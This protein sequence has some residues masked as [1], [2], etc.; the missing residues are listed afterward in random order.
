[1][2]RTS[3]LAFSLIIICSLGSFAT[4]DTGFAQYKIRRMSPVG[5]LGVN[6]QRDVRQDKWGF[7]WVITVNNLFRFD[8]Y[9]FKHYTNKL[10]KPETASAWSFERLEVDKSGDIYITSNVGLLKYNPLTDNFDYLVRGSVKMVEEDSQGRLWMSTPSALGLYN[11]KTLEFSPI[12]SDAGPVRN[13]SAICVNSRR[14]YV[15]T[16]TGDIYMFDENKGRCKHVFSQPQYNIVD[17]SNT[18]SILYVLTE[19]MGL[20]KISADTYREVQTYDFFYP[21]RDVRVSARALFIDKY[22]HL[23]I[24]S[25]RG[26]YIFNPINEEYTHYAYDKN[27]PYGMPSSSVWRISEDQQG[28]LWFGTYSGGLCFVNLN[29]RKKLRTFNG[30]IDDLSYTVVSS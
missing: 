15:G 11:R 22:K 28:N 20:I 21:E 30:R 18:D 14:I 5:G 8:G 27:D 6:G 2:M 29:E 3:L 4:D 17:I 7:V 1:M 24:T 25:Q 19:N 10:E 9:T 26:I 16:S 13:V 12:D 23:W